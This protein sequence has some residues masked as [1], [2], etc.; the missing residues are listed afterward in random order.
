MG[1][2]QTTA[3]APGPLELALSVAGRGYPHSIKG[4]AGLHGQQLGDGTCVSATL[5]DAKWNGDG[6]EMESNWEDEGL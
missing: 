4:V 5:I 1:L 3:W 2:W 6:M